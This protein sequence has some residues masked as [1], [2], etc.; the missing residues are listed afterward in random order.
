MK[1]LI[2]NAYDIAGGAARAAYRLHRALID[3]DVNSEM[4]V[5][6]KSSDDFTVIPYVQD[7][8][9]IKNRLRNLQTRSTPGYSR[10]SGT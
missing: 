7:F 8:G 10:T 6:G 4:L 5:I 9:R 2:V 3:S 1:I